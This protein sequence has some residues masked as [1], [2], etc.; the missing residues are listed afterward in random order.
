MQC[1]VACLA[2]CADDVDCSD[3]V[4]PVGMGAQLWTLNH[5]VL[6]TVKG[7]ARTNVSARSRSRL[8]VMVV[9]MAYIVFYAI[10]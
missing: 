10:S 6:M 5:C 8:M 4:A 3:S 1:W 7:N 9:M 2:V